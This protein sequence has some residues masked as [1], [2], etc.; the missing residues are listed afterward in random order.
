MHLVSAPAARLMTR[1]GTATLESLYDRYSA[2]LAVLAAERLGP[3]SHLD[4]V[5]DVTAEVWLQLAERAASVGLP[6][7]GQALAVLTQLLTAA[8]AHH[9][10]PRAEVPAGMYLPASRVLPPKQP[11]NIVFDFDEAPAL[12]QIAS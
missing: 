7:E 3:T 4:L 5:D 11:S 1:E 12:L 6:K 10:E 9:I 8:V 2:H